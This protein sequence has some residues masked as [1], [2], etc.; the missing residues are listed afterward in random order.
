MKIINAHKLKRGDLISIV[1]P[2]AGAGELFP[3]RIKNGIKSLEKM[4]FKVKVEKNALNRK[5]WI[6]G[7]IKERVSDIHSAFRDKKVKAI[8]CTIGGNHSNQLLKYLD[9]QLIRNNPK[10]FLGYSDI[11]VLHNAF[12]KKAGLR[13]FYGPCIISEFGEYPNLFLFTKEYFEKA[14]IEGEIGDIEQSKEWTDDFLDWFDVKNHKKTRKMVPNNKYEWWKKGSVVGEIFGGTIPSI[15]HLLGTEYE[16]NFKNKIFFLDLPEGNNPG[17]NL[18]LA[19]VDTCLANLFN[20]GVF[21]QIKGIVIGRPYGYRDDKEKYREL[22]EIIMGYTKE[23]KYPILFNAD[24]GHTS[25]MITI[26]IGAK[27]EINSRKNKFEIKKGFI[28]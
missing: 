25:P 5:K 18:S 20:A 10:I 9:Y 28:S 15:N 13:T 1:S 4:G 23:K 8:I 24:F 3:H 2:S 27:V 16:I 7:T 12:Y 17:E 21:E 26:P 14:L 22:R 6:S 19:D 11:T